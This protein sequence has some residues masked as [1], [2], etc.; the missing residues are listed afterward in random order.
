MSERPVF[1]VPEEPPPDPVVVSDQPDWDQRRMTLIEHLEELRRVLI[2]S[3]VAWGLA[4]IVGLA[5]S[6]WIVQV[7]TE[8]LRRLHYRPV[9]LSPM[10]NFTI[11]VKVGLL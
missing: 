7:L 8:P 4:S 10:D 9:V 6:F 3:L 11:Y 5:A 2:H 1:V